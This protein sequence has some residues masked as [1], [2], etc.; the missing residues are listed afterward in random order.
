[1]TGRKIDVQ[2]INKERNN[3]EKNVN[4]VEKSGTEDAIMKDS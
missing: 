2:I 1:M 3:A 4:V